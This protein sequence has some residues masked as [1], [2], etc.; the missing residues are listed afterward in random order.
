M[1]KGMIRKLKKGDR[2]A[3]RMFYEETSDRAFRIARSI[4]Q[5]DSLADD[6]V[7][8]SYIRVY[9]FRRTIDDTKSLDAWLNR[10]VI[11]E[12]YRLLERK[13]R[14]FPTEHFQ[15][16]S[17]DVDYKDLWEAVANL[18]E[19]HRTP[20]IL[21]Y[22]E[23]YTIQEISRMLAVNENTIKTRLATG[24]RYLRRFLEHNEEGIQ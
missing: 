1:Y 13:K 14:E 6:A 8:E 4:L 18:D 3:F 10:I 16:Q 7:Q 12:C 23:G 15:I 9:R 19:I 22:V 17:G 20:I 21:K 5:N 2:D 11:N 24:R